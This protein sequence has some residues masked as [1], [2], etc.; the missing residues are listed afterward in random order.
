MNMT[1]LI[2]IYVC[3]A[4]IVLI[5][6]W[7]FCSEIYES[8]KNNTNIFEKT[9]IIII[10]FVVLLLSS[11]AFI[12]IT[13]KINILNQPQLQTETNSQDQT[14]QK[15]NEITFQREVKDNLFY[16]L[17]HLFKKEPTEESEKYFKEAE[18]FYNAKLYS[19][20]VINYQKSID[21]L[22]TMSAYLNMGHSYNNISDYPHAMDTYKAGFEIADKRKAD[23]FKGTFL[24]N[25]GFVYW[26]QGDQN[27]ALKH[28]NKA[29]VID[30]EIGDKQNEAYVLNRMGMI[31]WQQGDLNSALKHYNEALV[32]DKKLGDTQEEASVLNNIGSVY[33]MQEYFNYAIK[34]YNEALNI[35]KEIGYRQG[36][37][38]VLGNLGLVY[39]K[40]GDLDVA[41][42]Y[43]KEAEAIFINIGAKRE[44]EITQDEIKKIE[45]IRKTNNDYIQK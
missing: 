43:Y 19:D 35:Y 8:Y 9:K 28:Y 44:L 32:I 22:P 4:V 14:I 36:M 40:I 42:K 39:A 6:G 13:N 18:R 12:N 30:K 41:I 3:L 15:A 23:S 24:Y 33:Y 21:K 45:S 25:M 27:S 34:N 29:L 11:Y 10:S 17:L 20:A 37:S 38:L 5:S 7:F 1:L 26:K 2:I 16:Y 31:Y